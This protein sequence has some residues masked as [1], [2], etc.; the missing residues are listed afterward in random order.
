[1]SQEPRQGVAEGGERRPSEP[2]LQA[3]ARPQPPQLVVVET[4][5]GS[6]HLLLA[7][8]LCSTVLK[9]NLENLI[10]MKFFFIVLI[11]LFPNWTFGNY[12]PV[13]M[14]NLKLIS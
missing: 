6:L 10:F 4:Q 12:R 8:P 7:P 3:Q 2:G 11:L 13:L 14:D 1:M 9:P 5:P